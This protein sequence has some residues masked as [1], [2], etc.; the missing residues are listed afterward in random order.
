LIRQCASAGTY[1]V[2]PYKDVSGRNDFLSIKVARD[3]R[4]IYF[5]A[6]TRDAIRNFR[7]S[8]CML[9]FINTH[10]GAGKAWEGYDLVVDAKGTRRTKTSLMRISGSELS[11]PVPVPMPVEANQLTI[12]I[13]QALL[14]QQRGRISLDFHWADNMA[15][16]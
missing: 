7:D 16:Y 12:A 1:K 14:E 8:H 11:S 13:P 3:Y 10:Q 5:Y 9:L 4:F 6:K 15:R 2:E